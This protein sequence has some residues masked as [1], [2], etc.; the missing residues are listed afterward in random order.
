MATAP[1]TP[2]VTKPTAT[3]ASDDNTRDSRSSVNQQINNSTQPSG[4]IKPRGNILDQFASYT[5]NIAWYGLTVDQFRSIKSTVNIDVSGWSL[6]VQS[7]GAAQQ[8]QGESQPA[9]NAAQFNK[10]NGPTTKLT[11]PNRN[12]YFTLDYYLDDLIIKSKV[13]GSN[14]TQTSEISFKVS[15]PNGIT[16]FS[17]LNYAIRDLTNTTPLMTQFCLVIKF[18][19]WDIDGN[20]VT[21]PTKNTGSN[22]ATP[23]ISNAIL[24][25]YYPFIISKIDFKLDGKAVV[26][27]VKGIP[28]QYN[29]ASSSSLGSIQSN[30]EFTGE[31]LQQVLGS[32]QNSV[33]NSQAAPDGREATNTSSPSEQLGPIVK[34]SSTEFN[35]TTN[36]M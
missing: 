27:E 28:V 36:I 4:L 11:T 32:T 20:L 34:N 23:N 35:I 31:T 24:T 25:R 7:G 17:N 9:S 13:T 10:I 18:Y 12:K 33:A 19:G 8:Q 15:E 6:L 5:Y 2:T 1:I 29:K 30:L 3:A 14:A 26:Y 21:D 16:L 22:G